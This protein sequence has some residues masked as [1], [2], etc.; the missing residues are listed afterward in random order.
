VQGTARWLPERHDARRC[1]AQ[2][3]PAPPAPTGAPLAPRLRSGPTLSRMSR[4]R[5]R[6]TRLKRPLAVALALGAALGMTGGLSEAT[7]AT[8]NGCT[9]DATSLDAQGREIDAASAPGR[10]GTKDDPLL[11]AA[12]GS[13]TWRG[14]SQQVLQ[15][16]SW[17]VRGGGLSLS[18]R[19][20]NEAGAQASSG[21]ADVAEYLPDVPGFDSLVSG[22]LH[23]EVTVRGGNGAACTTGGWVRLRTGLLGSLSSVVGLGLLAVSPFSL[24]WARAGLRGRS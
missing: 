15:N 2:A 4:T 19:L 6:P 12:D 21:R 9:W 5:H 10:G 14:S 13:V 11:I 23:V 24:A 16:G 8:A 7:A 18:R 1:V 22:L 3:R 20:G 17:N